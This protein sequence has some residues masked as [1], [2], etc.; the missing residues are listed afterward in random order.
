MDTLKIFMNINRREG[1]NF[2]KKNPKFCVGF[3]NRG[4]FCVINVKIHAFK[5]GIGYIG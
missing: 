5:R 1:V 2:D 4:S 3:R